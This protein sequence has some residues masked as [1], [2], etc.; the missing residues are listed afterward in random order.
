MN[1]F[2]AWWLGQFLGIMQLNNWYCRVQEQL[3]ELWARKLEAKYNNE[4]Y[5]EL[6]LIC[7]Q[8]ISPQAQACIVTK[9]I[10]MYIMLNFLRKGNAVKGYTVY[11]YYV[12][13]ALGWVN[14]LV[15]NKELR[16]VSEKCVY[17]R[18]LAYY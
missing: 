4:E 2:L 15:N 9:L 5:K 13:T 16:D 18:T 6:E 1:D 17:F 11:L 3:L 14:V 10:L 8:N 12:S 7:P